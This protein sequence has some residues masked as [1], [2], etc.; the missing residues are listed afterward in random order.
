MLRDFAVLIKECGFVSWIARG[1]DRLGSHERGKK[2]VSS[3]RFSNSHSESNFTGELKH[4]AKLDS[5]TT[6]SRRFGH[7]SK[8]S[9]AGDHFDFLLLA[10]GYSGDYLD[11]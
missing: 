3:H 4:V 5:A 1:A 2:F 7:R 6:V 8:L 11:R 10:A 9:C